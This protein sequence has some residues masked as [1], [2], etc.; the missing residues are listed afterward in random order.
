VQVLDLV[1]TTSSTLVKVSLLLTIFS[2]SLVS[3]DLSSDT[4][5]D[6]ISELELEVEVEVEVEVVFL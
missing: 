4:V 6:L 1:V 2:G 3:I 5:S